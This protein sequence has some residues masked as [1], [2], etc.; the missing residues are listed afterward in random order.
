MTKNQDLALEVESPFSED[1]NPALVDMTGHTGM[2]NASEA[3]L[4]VEL[5][6][7]KE[8]VEK[9]AEYRTPESSFV[10]G[11]IDKDSLP[12]KD[13]T[14]RMP[15]HILSSNSGFGGGQVIDFGKIDTMV[16]IQNLVIDENVYYFETKEGLWRLT[17]LD[18]GN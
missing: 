18:K 7:M 10:I 3:T 2:S 4:R 13:E 14:F 8:P 11:V 5:R 15:Y 17:V 6:R 9:G 12:T 1:L 16:A